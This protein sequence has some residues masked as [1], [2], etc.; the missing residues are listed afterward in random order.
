MALNNDKMREVIV[1][2]PTLQGEPVWYL[3]TGLG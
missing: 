2:A 1:A 3:R